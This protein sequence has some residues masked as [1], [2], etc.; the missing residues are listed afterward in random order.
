M[1]WPPATAKLVVSVALPP[2]P[3]AT[4]PRITFPSLKVTVP[5][6]VPRPGATAATVAVKVTAWPVTAGLTDDR[7]VSVVAAGLTVTLAAAEVLLA[8]PV[9]PKKVAVSE[10][11]PTNSDVVR[12]ALPVVSSGAE[13][14]S[15]LPSLKKTVPIGVPAGEVTVAVSVSSC[16]RTAFVS[17]ELSVVVVGASMTGAAVFNSTP[18]LLEEVLAATRSTRPSPFRSAAAT[19]RGSLPPVE[20]VSGDWNG[21]PNV[22]S[23]LPV[24]TVSPSGRAAC[25][26]TATSS[27]PSL[28][29]SARATS[30]APPVVPGP[31]K[32]GAR[33][34]PSPFPS[35]TPSWAMTLS[36][37]PMRLTTRSARPS[38]LTSPT[39]MDEGVKSWPLAAKTRGT[40]NVPSPRPSRTLTVSLSCFAA[41]TSSRPSPLKSPTAT[42]RGAPPTVTSMR[43]RKEPPPLPSSTL[44]L[45]WLFA[46]TR[47][48]APLPSKSPAAT[49]SGVWPTGRIRWFGWNEPS[50]L[51]SRTSTA[52]PEG[53]AVFR[54]RSVWPSPLKSP[55]ATDWAPPVAAPP[56]TTAVVPA[57]RN[58]G[59]PSPSSTLTLWEGEDGPALTT[60]RSGL[61]SRLKSATVTVRGSTPAGNVTG[62]RKVGT[63]RS[64]NAP[65][66]N[67]RCWA[68]RETGR[69]FFSRHWIQDRTTG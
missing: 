2:V 27:R 61:P 45:P 13:P 59:R 3:T 17:D 14:S 26:P 5:V 35:S 8:K 69:D 54:A 47:S 67:L 12:V 46:V 15:V 1:V 37:P 60:A 25:P 52:G 7:R 55:T 21:T 41:A 6:G 22:P 66:V 64:S 19:P 31:S 9:T 11:V 53:P 33:K 44:T 29:K 36:S 18:T 68:D 30:P 24:F 48:R 16:P 32:M 51:P 65:S 4:V 10:W 57:G 34:V 42:A 20:N 62:G 63:V 49:E 56:L 23:P 40:A 38:P 39:A 28:L 58:E 43:G 50:P